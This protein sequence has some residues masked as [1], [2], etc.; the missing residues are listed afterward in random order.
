MAPPQSVS[1]Q[2]SSKLV[3]KEFPVPVIPDTVEIEA[4]RLLKDT[5]R[6]VAVGD[7]MMGT[8]FP[9]TDYLPPNDGRDLLQ[10]V[11]KVLQRGDITFGNLE[12]VVEREFREENMSKHLPI[13]MTKYVHIQVLLDSEREK[14]AP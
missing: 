3:K 10:P 13:E 9:S 11:K 8:N 4:F 7:I 5:V 6:I 1:Q 2:D 12:G 14:A